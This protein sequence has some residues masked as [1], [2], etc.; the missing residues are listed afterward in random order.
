MNRISVFIFILICCLSPVQALA[1]EQD[2]ENGAGE[3]QG[4]PPGPPPATVKIVTAAQGTAA[5]TTDMIGT[6]YFERASRVSPE[7]AARITEVNFREGDRVTKGEVLI[8]LDSR[9]LKTELALQK[10]ML[11]RVGIRIEK[12]K[13]DLDR[14]TRL[15]EK[16][17]AT[18][19]DYDNLRF[20]HKELLQEQ[21]ALSREVDILT[22]RLAKHVVKAPF[23]GII[24]EKQAEVGEWIQP[25]S[26]LCLL[27][28]ADALY[29]QVPVAE[30]LIRFS[31]TGDQLPITLNA[32]DR[33]L[34]GV[35]EGVRPQADPKTKNISLKLRLDYTGPVAVNMSATVAVPVSEKKDLVM[36]P[37]DTLVQVM[38]TDMVYAVVDGKAVGMPVDIVYSSGAEIGVRFGDLKP[39]MTVV[40][41]GNERLQPGQPVSVLGE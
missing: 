25:G 4:Q 24:L 1:Q 8:R 5:S 28:A 9:I 6:L 27:G 32:F 39:G 14:Q 22:I 12:T 20:T 33:H 29:V 11:A 35:M 36:L 13:R 31:H 10:A 21:V 17:I 30:H 7:E 23:D 26:V 34:T 41:E 38:G 37:R 19:S 2:N 18:E 40:T 16:D 15:F 3:P